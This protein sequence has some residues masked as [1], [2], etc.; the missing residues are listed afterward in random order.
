MRGSG[1]SGVASQHGAD[2]DPAI[3][4]ALDDDEI[5]RAMRTRVTTAVRRIMANRSQSTRASPLPDPGPACRVCGDVFTDSEEVSSLNCGGG[6]CFHTRCIN[7]WAYTVR[8]PGGLRSRDPTSCLVCRG[9]IRES[10]AFTWQGARHAAGPA[11]EEARGQI[12]FTPP[13][14]SVSANAGSREA[15][16]SR[17]QRVAVLRSRSPLGQQTQ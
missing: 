6:H 5:A 12:Q 8:P 2:S 10:S 1:A 9:A 7:R 4:A 16:S 13:S 15:S 17:A 11:N 3:G 14:A